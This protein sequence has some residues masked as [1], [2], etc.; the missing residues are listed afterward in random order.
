MSLLPWASGLGLRKWI[1]IRDDQ[2]RRWAVATCSADRSADR[3]GGRS[4]ATRS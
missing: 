2:R 4:E 3:D 1:G